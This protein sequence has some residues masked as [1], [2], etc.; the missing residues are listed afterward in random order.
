MENRELQR[1]SEGEWQEERMHFPSKK[2]RQ[3]ADKKMTIEWRHKGGQGNEQCGYLKEKHFQTQ[4]I[5]V[6]V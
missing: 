6:D 4:E 1:E 5:I 3:K 2:G